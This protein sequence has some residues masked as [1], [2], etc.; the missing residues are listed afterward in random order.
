MPT[1]VTVIDPGGPEQLR[2]A[3]IVAYGGTCVCCGAHERRLLHVWDAHTARVAPSTEGYALLHSAGYPRAFQVLCFLCAAD[4]PYRGGG[5]S[6]Q[7]GG[8]HATG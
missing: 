1:L 5:C 2:D 4:A 7:H 6:H 8:R 3:A